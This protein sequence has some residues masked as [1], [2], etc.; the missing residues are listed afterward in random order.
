M[1]FFM[2]ME[3]GKSNIKVP[4]ASAPGESSYPARRRGDGHHLAL[5][6]HDGEREKQRERAFYSY[7]TASLVGYHSIPSF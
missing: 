4:V 6:S 5:S 1:Y 2:V 3:G 7:K